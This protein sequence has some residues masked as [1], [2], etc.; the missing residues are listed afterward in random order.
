MEGIID[1]HFLFGPYD[2]YVKTEV[3]NSQQLYDIVIKK[4]RDI[5]GVKSPMTCFIA[6]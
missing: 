1:A 4:I 2:A 6:Y 5:E 3:E